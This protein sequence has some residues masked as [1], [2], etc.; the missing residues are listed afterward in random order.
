MDFAFK[1]LFQTVFSPV[2]KE[3]AQKL[4]RFQK[5]Q[6]CENSTYL[7]VLLELLCYL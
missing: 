5:D 7:Q 4:Q 2:R 3:A 1:F 6:S